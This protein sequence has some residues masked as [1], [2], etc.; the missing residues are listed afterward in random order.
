MLT[1]TL[2][3]ARTAPKMR[4]GTKTRTYKK[5]FQNLVCKENQHL[6][7]VLH[8]RLNKMIQLQ[9]DSLNFPSL[10]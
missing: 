9:L 4:A 6:P 1:G 8:A 10:E 2:R 7:H 3:F 5:C